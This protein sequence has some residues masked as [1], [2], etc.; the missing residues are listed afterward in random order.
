MEK[1]AKIFRG[2]EPTENSKKHGVKSIGLFSYI[3]RNSFPGWDG[4][5]HFNKI[6]SYIFGPGYTGKQQL[7]QPTIVHCGLMLLL[8]GRPQTTDVV[9]R[10]T[11]VELCM[12]DFLVFTDFQK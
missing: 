5:L 12:F 1:Y 10:D 3:K 4:Q 2:P 7:L 9:W 6:L 8:S 11:N